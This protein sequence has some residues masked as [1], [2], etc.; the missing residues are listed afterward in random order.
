MHRE[1]CLSNISGQKEGRGTTSS[2]K[3]EGSKSV[4]AGGALQDG[5]STPPTRSI[6]TRGLDDRNGSK[7]CLFPNPHTPESPALPPVCLGRE[8]LQVSESFLWPVVCTTIVYQNLETSGGL[9][10]TD[11]LAPDSISG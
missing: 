4:C 10:K 6:T 7:R 2:N 9:V 8:T 1:L 3:S 5:G 11:G